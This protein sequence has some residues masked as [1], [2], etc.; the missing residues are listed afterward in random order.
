MKVDHNTYDKILVSLPYIF[1]IMMEWI[2]T[3]IEFEIVKNK[4]WI[5]SI[6]V[7]KVDNLPPK[8]LHF[9]RHFTAKE[10]LNMLVSSRFI[11]FQLT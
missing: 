3:W 10:V 6:L 4:V 11:G 2:V 7:F 8:K 1:L 5:V 9:G